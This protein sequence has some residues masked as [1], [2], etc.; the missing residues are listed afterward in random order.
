[1]GDWQLQLRH[2]R[3][4]QL[5]CMTRE[6]IVAERERFRAYDWEDDARAT[7]KAKSHERDWVRLVLGHAPSAQE[8]RGIS[9]RVK[10]NPDQAYTCLD[11]YAKDKI[12][13]V[14]VQ[15][16]IVVACRAGHIE[17]CYPVK[18][19]DKYLQAMRSWINTKE[20]LP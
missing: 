1:M 4:S 18:D 6:E 8:L 10:A 16:C 12:A 3:E 11:P 14:F 19:L 5:V 15:G 7:F 13:W 17:T 9:A 20:Y 2:T